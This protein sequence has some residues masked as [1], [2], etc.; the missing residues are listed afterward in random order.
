MNKEMREALEQLTAGFE[1]LKAATLNEAEPG[2]AEPEAKKDETYTLGAEGAVG[3]SLSRIGEGGPIFL[4]LRGRKK[5][6]MWE[7]ESADNAREWIEA[8]ET[9][10][11]E[12]KQREE[13][14]ES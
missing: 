3:A 9:V 11:K 14:E 12:L 2:E 10:E 6:L 7:I 8:F 13:R 1:A 5:N 4:V